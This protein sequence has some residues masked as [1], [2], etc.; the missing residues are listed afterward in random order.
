MQWLESIEKVLM[1]MGIPF[2]K[3]VNIPVNQIVIGPN[4]VSQI[5]PEGT[6]ASAISAYA[7]SM[8]NG[9]SELFPPAVL[10]RSPDGTYELI[11]GIHRTKARL[12][13]KIKEC[14]AY[15]VETDNER[16]V[17][18]LR[19][20]LN[21]TGTLT[22]FTTRIRIM[23]AVQLVREG[24]KLKEA[25][26]YM[27]V[28][29][30]SVS[31]EIRVENIREDLGKRSQKLK[32]LK[33]TYLIKLATIRN[34]EIAFDAARLVSEFGLKGK[35]VDELVDGINAT[36]SDNAARDVLSTERTRRERLKAAPQGSG[37]SSTPR[38]PWMD[39]TNTAKG[40]IS[41]AERKE[42]KILDSIVGPTEEKDILGTIAI[43]IDVLLKL[44]DKIKRRPQ[45]AKGRQTTRKGARDHAGK[46]PDGL[47]PPHDG[48]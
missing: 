26:R 47:H 14:H 44:S 36:R 1:E 12:E 15:V 9:Q 4:V 8:R 10:W 7:E 19:R 11:D 24:Y 35:E 29:A 43:L 41:R 34:D 33:R 13:A 32:E 48:R 28:S 31:K 21:A 3:E 2:K 46:K 38:P 27:R 16:A 6:D 42:V 18:V 5:R 23:L 22:E 40:L 20:V 17:L 37:V 30:E 25:A 39:F 45:R